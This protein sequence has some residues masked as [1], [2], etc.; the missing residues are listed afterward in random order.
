MGGRGQVA[1]MSECVGCVQRVLGED[2]ETGE[3]R[4]VGRK[5]E[6]VDSETYKESNEREERKVRAEVR[7]L[8]A[9]LLVVLVV[10]VGD[11][12]LG[13]FNILPAFAGEEGVALLL[14]SGSLLPGT[15]GRG[16]FPRWRGGRS[17]DC[18]GTGG[19]SDLDCSCAVGGGLVGEV[20]S[21]ASCEWRWGVVAGR[22]LGS[23][24]AVK[25]G[26]GEVAAGG[27]VGEEGF[28]GR[29]FVRVGVLD[30][31]FFLPFRAPVTENGLHVP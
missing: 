11:G 19:R 10:D 27:G 5:K 13:P 15:L 16:D 7:E 18:G 14:F 24:E 2:V 1:S 6:G 20:D 28:P 29:G 26:V 31:K 30:Q 4:R 3:K 23:L 12:G 22:G 25:I 8:V 9:K 21:K 17:L